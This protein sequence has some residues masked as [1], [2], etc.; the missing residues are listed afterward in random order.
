MGYCCAAL[1]AGWDPIAAGNAAD[2]GDAEVTADA[3]FMTKGFEELGICSEPP[4]V[5]LEIWVSTEAAWAGDGNV[6]KQYPG[7][8]AC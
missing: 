3:Q 4:F 8:F 1:A 2:M 6:K 5:P 7:L